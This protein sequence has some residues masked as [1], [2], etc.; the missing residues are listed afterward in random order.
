MIYYFLISSIKFEILSS[1]RP[2]QSSLDTELYRAIV[3]ARDRFE[4]NAPVL[5][6]PLTSTT[7]ASAL[8]EI[9]MVVYGFEPYHLTAEEDTSHGDDERISIDNLRSGLKI[10]FAI[11]G[12][13]CHVSYRKGS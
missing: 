8:R 3:R 6:P 2:T 4:P 9:G 7:D 10:V 13:V 11:V 5:S 12:D 1:G